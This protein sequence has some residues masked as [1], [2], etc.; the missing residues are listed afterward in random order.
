MKKCS[1][2]NYVRTEQDNLLF[3]E[4]ECPSCG[5]IEKYKAKFEFAQLEKQRKIERA[6]RLA[7]IKK[8]EERQRKAEE[9][10]LR[11]EEEERK[12][13]EEAERL[14]KLEEEKA[15]Q[16]ELE[17]LLKEEEEKNKREKLERKKKEEAEKARLKEEERQRKAEEE[18]L[19]K[20]EEER[21]AR[22]EA[23]RLKKLETEKKRKLEEERKRKEEEERFKKAAEEERLRKE[24]EERK[25]REEA[26]RQKKL[27]EEK[28]KEILHQNRDRIIPRTQKDNIYQIF[29]MCPFVIA[30][31]DTGLSFPGFGETKNKWQ[32]GSCMK[33]HCRLWTYRISEEDDVYAQGCSL[34]FLGLSEEEIKKNFTIKNTR[35]LQ[36]ESS[37]TDEIR[38]P[39]EEG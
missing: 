36:E 23:V 33:E 9:E 26:A 13:R 2:C 3:P 8:E 4:Y 30:Q 32:H 25:A 17:R 27:K 20:E 1:E 14:K 28:D 35:I 6:D 12:A 7:K 5:I 31:R 16:Q 39:N 22:E 37:S 11:K 10:R 15:R 38:N 18:M 24:E 19:R 21:K 29:D 34:Q